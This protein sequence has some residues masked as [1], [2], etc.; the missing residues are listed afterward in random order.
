MVHTGAIV[1][2]HCPHCNTVVATLPLGI[3]SWLG[4]PLY[5]C[6]KCGLSYDS[7]RLEWDDMP[8]KRKAWYVA[9]SLLY[10]CALG[11]AGGASVAGCVHFLKH[12]PWKTEVPIE[13]PQTVVGTLACALL[14]V[15]CQIGR[16]YRSRERRRRKQSRMTGFAD[17]LTG[18]ATSVEEPYRPAFW[19][20][21]RMLGL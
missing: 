5:V 14:V 8:L 1:D 7:G 4:P 20:E 18:E 9:M 21:L 16:V 3:C 11:W 17:P 10:T 19:L 13:T 6:H 15:I 12:G 2:F